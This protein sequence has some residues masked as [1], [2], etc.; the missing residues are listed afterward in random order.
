MDKHGI[1]VDMHY[2]T[3]CHACEIACKQEN[4][5]PAG[6]WGVKINEMITTEPDSDH[7]HFDYVPYFTRKCNL[8]ASR[9][10]S[11]EEERP[12]CV[13]HCGTAS[14]HYG[15]I[16]ELSKKMADMPRAILYNPL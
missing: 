16:A 13:K 12:A 5:F 1:L 8:C 14:M 2:C 7:V 10:A 6:V 9:I 3:G 11:G 15:S 4:G